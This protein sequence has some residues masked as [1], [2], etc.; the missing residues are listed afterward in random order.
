MAT[1]Q[2]NRCA[3]PDCTCTV[4]PENAI[5]RNGKHYCSQTC[6]EGHRDGT[7]GCGHSGCACGQ[8]A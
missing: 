6:A 3:C 4:S 1:Q 2:Q 8:A 5:E 7:T